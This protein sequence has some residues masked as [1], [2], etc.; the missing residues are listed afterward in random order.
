MP[1][2]DAAQCFWQAV[3]RRH[4]RT[5]DPQGHQ[6]RTCF[7]RGQYFAADRIVRIV[8]AQT[9]VGMAYAEKGGRDEQQHDRTM[10]D[11]T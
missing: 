1:L 2:G 7:E 11:G 10:V 5:I 4:R 9:P 6:D 3:G 8:D